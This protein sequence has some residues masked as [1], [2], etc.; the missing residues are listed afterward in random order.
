MLYLDQYVY[1]NKLRISHPLEKVVFATVNLVCC[2]AADKPLVPLVVAALMLTLLSRAAKIPGYVL[3]RLMLAPAAFLLLGGLT[4]AVSVSPSAAGMLGS[5]QL[6]TIYLGVTGQSLSLAAVTLS[7]SLG[8]TSALYFLVLT[9]PLSELLYVFKLL[10]VPSVVTELG[11]LVYR[12][13][14]VFLETAFG[15]YNAQSA[16]LGFINFKRSIN[17]FGLLFA[18]VWT[19]AFFRSQALYNSLLARGYNGSLE[20][21]NPEF[22]F[23]RANTAGFALLSCGVIILAFVA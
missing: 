14:F 18:N 16:R 5:L 11:M 20:V 23:V 2:V 6:G 10:R 15:I 12:F 9:T 21:L 3:T 1:R 22:K 4:I 19:S 7:K 8:A 13:I 17:S